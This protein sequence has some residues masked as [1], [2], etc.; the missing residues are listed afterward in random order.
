MR[1]TLHGNPYFNYILVHNVGGSGDVAAVALRGENSRW[2]RMN[3]NWGQ[4]WSCGGWY[5][6]QALSFKVT[7]GSGRSLEFWNVVD[8]NWGFGQTYESDYNF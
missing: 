6:G 7:L 4:Y 8:K 3:Q 5:L 1:F 2:N